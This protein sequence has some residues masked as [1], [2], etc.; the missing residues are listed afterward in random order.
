MNSPVLDKLLN[1]SGWHTKPGLARRQGYTLH[2]EISTID[3][4]K[5][6]NIESI[7]GLQSNVFLLMFWSG[8]AGTDARYQ[9][10]SES[11]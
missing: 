6:Y 10:L 8:R 2:V 5:E 11:A 7:D 9:H 4:V 3:L 1:I